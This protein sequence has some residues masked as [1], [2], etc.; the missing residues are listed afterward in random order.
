MGGDIREQRQAILAEMPSGP[1]VYQFLSADK[2][3]LYVGKA[4]NL[5]KRVSSYFRSGHAA[6]TEALMQTAQ[7]IEVTRTHTEGEALLLENNLIKSKQ[8][9]FNIMLRDDKGY[10]YIFLSDQPYPRLVYHRGAK[11]EKGRYFGPYP[12]S[13]SVRESLRLLQKIFGVR[14]CRDSYF[15]NRSRP[16]L[17]YQLKR[18]SGPCVGIISEADYA[19]DVQN[20]VLF[21]EG[22]GKEL[23]DQMIAKMDQAAAALDYETAAVYRDRIAALHRVQERQYVEGDRLGELDI[24]CGVMDQGLACIDVSTVRG[25][26]HLGRRSYFPTSKTGNGQP[27]ELGE[28]LSAFVSQY[29]QDKTVPPQ[30]LV[31]H[32]VADSDLLE[33]ALSE[34]ASHK[35]AIRR[36]QRGAARKWMDMAQINA[37]DALGRRLASKENLR[38]RFD[39]L[40][41]AL[42]LE[43][44]VE[45]IECFDIS[46]TGGEATVA[47]CVVFTP[48]GPLKTDYRRYNIDGIEPGDD[49]AA[50]RQAL[51][52]R[53]RKLSEGEGKV[54]DLL[55]VDGGKGQ[56]R[57]AEEIIDEM[58]IPG[59]ALAGIAKGE[60]RKAVNDRLFLSG[61][62][63]ATILPANSPAMHLVQQIRDE[64]H[65]FAIS[66]HRKQRGRKR[67]GS[68]LENIEG[69]G[70]KRRQSLLRQLGGIREVA[71]AGIEDLVGV[72]GISPQMAQKMYDA[73]HEQEN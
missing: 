57:Q 23:N 73:F 33:A 52:R 70:E 25:G 41:D 68:V 28:V 19:Q 64:A 66:G 47:S 31:N 35:V 49:Y 20:T 51:T 62:S 10:P 48:D 26:R 55:L 42:G 7:T 67:S 17:Q 6:K 43:Q 69:I 13:G 29:Y 37:T 15:S 53:F 24:I 9:R 5:K 21:L 16:C 3:V 11:R 65:R 18:C 4:R 22:K 54:P 32:D 27:D 63:E 1:G 14:Q 71:R 40:Q 60:G 12:S 2:E 72:P 39:T 58:Q 8:P 30:I 38:Q 46:H 59:V 50:M 56:L 44:Q 34:V 36:P 61:Q 45:R